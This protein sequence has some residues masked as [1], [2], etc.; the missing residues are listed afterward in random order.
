MKINIKVSFINR[1]NRTYPKPI[2]I[3]LGQAVIVKLYDVADG[4]FSLN[5]IVEFIGI[6]SLDPSLAQMPLEGSNE[7]FAE[8]HHQENAARNPPASLVPR[9]HVLHHIKL[10]HSNPLLPAEKSSLEKH[11]NNNLTSIQQEARACRQ[12][13]HSM[14]TSILLGDSLAADYLICHLISRIYHRRDVLCLGKF[15]LNMFNMP[16]HSNYTKRLAT[17]LQL[18]LTKSHYL[19]LTVPNLNNIAY[20]PKKD[21]HANRLVSGLLQLSAQTHLILD[22]TTMENGQ[23]NTYY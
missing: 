20:V 22:E 8:F 23:V 6:V 16:T 15:S 4:T 12:E 14:L 21:Y 5:E 1:N 13:L 7:I 11:L 19:P 9:V 10:V 3:L 2:F 18:L 17:V